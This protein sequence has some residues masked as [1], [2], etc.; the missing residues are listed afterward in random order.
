MGCT[1]VT[2]ERKVKKNICGKLDYHPILDF[3]KLSG[4]R[5]KFKDY[6]GPHLAASPMCDY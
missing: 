3:S 4:V 1:L 2:C 5:G 6:I